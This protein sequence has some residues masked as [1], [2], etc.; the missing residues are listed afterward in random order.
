MRRILLPLAVAV[1]LL[2]ACAR[3]RPAPAAVPIY[4]VQWHGRITIPANVPDFYEI[5]VE[6][7]MYQLPGRACGTVGDVR[8]MIH[9]PRAE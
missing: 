8:A 7:P 9:R 1:S 6:D 5:C 3:L 2:P 4:A